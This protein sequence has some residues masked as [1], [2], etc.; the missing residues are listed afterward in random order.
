MTVDL[1]QTI[2]AKSDQLNADDLVGADPVTIKITRVQIT[3][4][5]EQPIAISYEGDN[6]KPYMP[7]KS[8]RRVLVHAWGTDGAVYVGRSLTLYRDPEV[9]F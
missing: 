3:G 1:T 9:K 5:A 7:G 2:I 6:G 4:S 8:M